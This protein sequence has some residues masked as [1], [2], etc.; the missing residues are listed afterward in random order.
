MPGSTLTPTRYK[1]TLNAV[2][3]THQLATAGGVLVI[4]VIVTGGSSAAA[5][6]VYDSSAGE[7]EASPSIDSFLISAN[8]GESTVYCPSR[9]VLMDRGL[10]IELEQGAAFQGEAFITYDVA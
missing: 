4:S 7:G 9:P 5:V 8:A 1:V 2:S 6:R 10:Y 3:P